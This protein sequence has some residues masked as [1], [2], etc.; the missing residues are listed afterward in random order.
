MS[1]DKRIFLSWKL[2]SKGNVT[3]GNNA[4]SNIVGKG[5]VNLTNRRVKAKDV[6]FVHN[7]KHNLLSVSH[8][9]D[10]AYDVLFKSKNCQTK[11]ERI[12]EIVV[13]VVRIDSNVNVLKGKIDKCCLKNINEE[14]VV[15]SKAKT[16]EL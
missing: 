15:A 6:S 10:I 5:I 16:Y 12:G 9:C 3:F 14:M 1:G 7:P 8:M 4:P 11:S 2:V 13:Q